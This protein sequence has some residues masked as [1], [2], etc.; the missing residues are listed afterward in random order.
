[1]KQFSRALSSS[2]GL[3]AMTA[4][5]NMGRSLEAKLRAQTQMWTFAGHLA[6]G[7]TTGEAAERMRLPAQDGAK[8]L[9]S[10]RRAMGWQAR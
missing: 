8:L 1:M 3:F 10:L 2:A 6:D 9:R 7:A 4:P 5:Q